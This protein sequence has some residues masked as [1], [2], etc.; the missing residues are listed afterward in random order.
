M[1]EQ[2]FGRTLSVGVEEELMILD[3]VL[4]AKELREGAPLVRDRG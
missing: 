3:A 2:N 1:I 4:M